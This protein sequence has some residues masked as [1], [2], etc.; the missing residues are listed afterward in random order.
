[1]RRLV[2][3]APPLGRSAPE[4]ELKIA[5]EKREGA[6]H[7]ASIVDEVADGKTNKQRLSLTLFPSPPDG[8]NGQPKIA[9]SEPHKPLA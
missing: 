3:L 1:M 7:V 8:P 6:T 4:R 2:R 9:L 5:T